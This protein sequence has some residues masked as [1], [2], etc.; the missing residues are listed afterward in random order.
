MAH[1][2]KKNLSLFI[3]G[4]S[5]FRRNIVLKQKRQEKPYIRI[6]WFTAF[7]CTREACMETNGRGRNQ[8]LEVRATMK[9]FRH[10]SILSVFLEMHFCLHLV[11]YLR[12]QCALKVKAAE[13]FCRVD[14][15]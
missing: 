4:S 7:T 5:H 10:T 3:V 9:Q 13:K 14:F 12:I 6:S 15:L 11:S 1:E 8:I 2:H